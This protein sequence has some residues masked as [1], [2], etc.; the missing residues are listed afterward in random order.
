M[1]GFLS[2]NALPTKVTFE[3][4]VSN[5]AF[6]CEVL[7]LVSSVQKNAHENFLLYL[8]KILKQNHKKHFFLQNI[9]T[10]ALVFL[11]PNSKIIFSHSMAC[12]YY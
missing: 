12:K 2:S 10:V 1:V 3:S 8:S 7:T 11:Q 9:Q 4:N 5:S 6:R